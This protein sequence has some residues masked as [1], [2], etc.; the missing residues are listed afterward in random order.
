MTS[1]SQR[2]AGAKPAHWIW[3]IFPQLEGLGRSSPARTYA[4]YEEI[5]AAVSDQ[6]ARGIALED[7]MGS[8]LDALKLVSSLTFFRAPA[9]RPRRRGSDLPLACAALLCDPQPNRG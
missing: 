3:H 7:P 1:P 2:F 4:R 5:T 9:Q 8:R 6:L